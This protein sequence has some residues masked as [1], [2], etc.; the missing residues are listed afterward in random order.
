M[1][2]AAADC[3]LVRAGDRYPTEPHGSSNGPRL[4]NS[5]VLACLMLARIEWAASVRVIPDRADAGPLDRRYAPRRQ[6]RRMV[7]RETA[8]TVKSE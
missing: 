4:V 1:Q 8:E 3:K 2:L 6:P 5:A 7:D